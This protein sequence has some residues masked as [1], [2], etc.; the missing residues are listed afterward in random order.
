MVLVYSAF[1]LEHA[2]NPEKIID[3]AI[4]HVGKKGVVSFLAPNFG[5]PNRR[6]PNSI[7]N[8][9]AKIIN[10]LRNDFMYK[11]EGLG[12]KKVFPKKGRY[13]N[14]D[15]DARCEP[16]LLSLVRYIE[17]RGLSVEYKS[18]LWEL[19]SWSLNLRKTCFMLLG[20][21]GLFPFN[22]WGP[23]LFVVA[24]RVT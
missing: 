17:K 15:D 21:L 6:S 1:V 20:K 12:W 19:E 16:Y 2:E 10:G 7:E 22:Y 23:Q 8:K 11:E 18:S 24:R 5:A 3:T 13:K 9:R 14:P 4:N